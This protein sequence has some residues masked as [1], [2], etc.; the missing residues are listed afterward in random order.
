MKVYSVYPDSSAI[1]SE[2]FYTNKADAIG[3][4]KYLVETGETL[5]ATVT[6]NTIRAGKGRDL[7]V[8]LLNR[9]GYT[10]GHGEVVM[11]F[12]NKDE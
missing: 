11:T 3:R 9:V 8:A 7:I 4:A 12:S 10:T 1:E 6:L 2:S 5:E